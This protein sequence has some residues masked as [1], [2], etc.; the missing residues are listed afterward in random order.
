MKNE[1]SKSS[2]FVDTTRELISI[3]GEEA[4]NFLQKIITQD[5]IVNP[6]K[7]KYSALLNPQ[8][9]YLFDFFIFKKNDFFILDIDKNYSDDLIEKINFYKLRANIEI[10]KKSGY[11][12]LTRQDF[13]NFNPDPRHINLYNRGYFFDN[14]IPDCDFFDHEKNKFLRVKYCIP[15]NGKELRINETYILEAGFERING[16]DFKKGCFIGQEVTSR[17]KHKAKLRK[18][19]VKVKILDNSNLEGES[20]I[21]ENKNVGKITTQYENYA[22]A[23]L[24][25]KYLK[26]IFISGKSR[27]KF[28]EDLNITSYNI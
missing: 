25:F 8:G 16:L 15:E 23:Y 4:S 12:I 9:K 5:V 28:H 3:K 2:M 6:Y 13:T 10:Q 11:V 22:I 1:N 19:Y 27:I 17:M 24:N 14:K 26:D 20:I 18:G 21:F 7:L